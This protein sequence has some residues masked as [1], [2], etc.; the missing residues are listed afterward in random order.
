MQRKLYLVFQVTVHLFSDGGDC[1][2]RLSLFC[3]NVYINRRTVKETNYNSKA[4]KEQ[5]SS[6]LGTSSG[7]SRIQMHFW[8]LQCIV[9]IKTATVSH[10]ICML[11]RIPIT[12][13]SLSI[14]EMNPGCFFMALI[15]VVSKH[16]RYTTELNLTTS[17]WDR[18]EVWTWFIDG[19]LRQGEIVGLIQNPSI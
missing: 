3:Q 2:L 17:S 16:L 12:F 10:M 7:S 8:E 19:Q 14:I 1:S 4:G 5:I 11:F 6:E 18:K 13:L 9:M 15:T